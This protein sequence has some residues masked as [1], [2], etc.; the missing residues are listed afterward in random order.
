MPGCQRKN[1]CETICSSAT[2]HVHHVNTALPCHTYV[3]V[4]V[5]SVCRA[6]SHNSWRLQDQGQKKNT[7]IIRV[8]WERVG[9]NTPRAVPRNT[10]VA[11]G[12]E[13]SCRPDR[14]N[15]FVLPAN[16]GPQEQDRDK[17]VVQQLSKEE[18]RRVGCE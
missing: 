11:C 4:R 1:A 5:R 16:H 13:G 9:K 8:A 14:V 2:A 15:P 7:D 12:S 6:S 17:D 3:E 10:L 18:A